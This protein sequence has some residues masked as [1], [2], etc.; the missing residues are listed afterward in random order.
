MSESRARY[1]PRLRR[2]PAENSA[3]DMRRVSPDCADERWPWADERWPWADEVR[4]FC[5]VG[6]DSP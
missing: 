1:R 2:P 5:D 4:G 3:A 6:R